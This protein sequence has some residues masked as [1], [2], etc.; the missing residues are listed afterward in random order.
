MAGNL[1]YLFYKDYYKNIDWTVFLLNNEDYEYRSKTDANMEEYMRKSE[2]LISES[3]QSTL[4]LINE[5][6]YQQS[7]KLKTT[8]PGLVIGTGYHHQTKTKGEFKLGFYFDHTTGMPLIPGSSLKGLLR[9]AFPNRG[10][11]NNSEKEEY[12]KSLLEYSL[13]AEKAG[14]IS[15]DL[16]EKEI[17]EGIKN[18]D[19]TEPKD[20]YYPMSKRDIFFDAFPCSTGTDGL[21]STDFITPH[22]EKPLKNPIPLMFLKVSP[23]VEFQFNF[24]VK[25]GKTLT[26]I[27]KL[28]LFAA[29][30]LDFGIGAKTNVGYGKFSNELEDVYQKIEK[31]CLSPEEKN[32]IINKE[33]KEELLKSIEVFKSNEKESF[34]KLFSDWQSSLE[35]KNDIEIANMFADK[36]DR[37]SYSEQFI[38]MDRML[39]IDHEAELKVKEQRRE[40]AE[41]NAIKKVPNL[42]TKQEF[43][44]FINNVIA[45]KSKLT[46]EDLENI[47]INLKKKLENAASKKKFKKKDV[48]P[49]SKS[50]IDLSN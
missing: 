18:N 47:V 19:A 41:V 37:E 7:F 12:I 6:N 14:K 23:D 16:L 13:G 27:E 21:L 24:N 35:I 44:S 9:S 25:D 48:E 8:Y 43:N 46:K 4:I 40:E 26:K 11:K 42:S 3:K 50:I 34:K 20:K 15:I 29:I 5:I 30:L 10:T 45:H 28:K 1:G 17:F 39:G 38:I 31:D 2:K 33:K 36:L 22:K 32:A 49:I